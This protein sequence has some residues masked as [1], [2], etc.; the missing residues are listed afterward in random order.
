MRTTAHRPN[1]LAAVLLAGAASLLATCPLGA[2]MED[3]D[4]HK[5]QTPS[6]TVTGSGE[7]REAPDEARVSLGVVA[8]RE[9]AQEAQQ[10]ANRIA[11]SILDGVAALDVPEEAIQTSQLVLTPV[12][13][14]GGPRQQVPTEPRIIAYRATNV[15][16]VRLQD[17]SKI[18]PVI[19]AGIEAG[20]NR[21]EGVSFQLRDDREARQEALRRAVAEAGAKARAMAEALEISLGSVLHAQEGGVTIETPRF[22]GPRMMTMEARAV[23]TPVSPGEVTVTGNVTLRYRI[24]E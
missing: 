24:G 2:Q 5:E 13:Q 14:Q 17:L 1:P 23:E 20:A 22:G 3:H 10:E 21:V 9:T 6:I 16:T 11:Q 8:Q 7:V 18:G 19:D 4:H 15:V 12:Y